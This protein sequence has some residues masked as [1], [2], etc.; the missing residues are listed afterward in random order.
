MRT[1]WPSMIA[2]AAKVMAFMPDAQTLL[3]V[4]ASAETGMPA[5]IMAW[6]AGAWPRLAETTLPM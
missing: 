5:P 1:R 6:R 2:W 4:V 3:M